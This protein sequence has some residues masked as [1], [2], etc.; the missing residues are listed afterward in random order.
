MKNAELW[1]LV[2]ERETEFEVGR[3]GIR[4]QGGKEREK[5]GAGRGRKKRGGHDGLVWRE[6]HG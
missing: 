2:G 1:D 5:A 4:G 6:V 3:P